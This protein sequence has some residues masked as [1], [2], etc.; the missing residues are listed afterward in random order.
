MSRLSAELSRPSGSARLGA[1]ALF[2]ETA[3]LLLPLLGGAV[4][5]GLCLKYDWLASLARPIDRGATW[6]GRPL[7]GRNKTW[8][9]I[10][11]VGL[12]GAAVGAL[13][14]T[15]IE[16]PMIPLGVAGGVLFG[17][18]VG[19]AAMLG[20]LPNSLW[21]RR[22]GVAPGAPVCGPAA[23]LFWAFDQIDLLLGAWPVWWLC[24]DVRAA[25]LALSAAIVLIV[26]QLVTSAG[27]ALGMRATAR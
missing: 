18:A 13:Q 27:H 10:V 9:G 8:R 21:K 17:L 6:R 19:S 3:Y 25:H 14:A 4:F 2:G 7:L 24:A 26:H 1:L 15:V 12:G 20:E 22:L 11:A 5:H 16:L 23:P